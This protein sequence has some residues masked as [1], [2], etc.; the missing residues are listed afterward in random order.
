MQGMLAVAVQQPI[1]IGV[2]PITIHRI[3]P[4]Q[5]RFRKNGYHNI[6]C[7]H[8]G[9]N[10]ENENVIESGEIQAG[11]MNDLSE[12]GSQAVTIGGLVLVVAIHELHGGHVILRAHLHHPIR[13]VIQEAQVDHLDTIIMHPTLILCNQQL[14]SQEHQV[15]DATIQMHVTNCLLHVVTMTA[16]QV[17]HRAFKV[18]MCPICHL[19]VQKAF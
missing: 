12:A 13:V 8:H 2:H 15:R 10:L 18:F 16:Y 6:D 11:L 1:L 17:P 3:H 9:D 5:S 19:R 7:H 14:S 4:H